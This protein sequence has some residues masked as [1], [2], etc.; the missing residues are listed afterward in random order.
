M[1]NA[2]PVS[3]TRGRVHVY[4]HI[5]L[6]ARLNCVLS[7]THI[8]RRAGIHTKPALQHSMHTKSALQHGQTQSSF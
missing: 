2:S 4:T 6:P 3:H 5:Q 8:E 7:C 1:T